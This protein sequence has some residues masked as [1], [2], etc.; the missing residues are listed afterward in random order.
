MQRA[1]RGCI[2][3]RLLSWW[4]GKKDRGDFKGTNDK[5]MMSRGG[6]CKCYYVR[7]TIGPASPQLQVAVLCIEL[8]PRRRE[9]DKCGEKDT[10]HVY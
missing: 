9:G 8:G 10:I 4:R 3:M 2:T 6:S 7:N 5:T 1:S